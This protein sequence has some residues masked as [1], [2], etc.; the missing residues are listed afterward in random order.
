MSVWD[1]R[2]CTCKRVLYTITTG[3]NLMY[4]NRLIDNRYNVSHSIVNGSFY[5][6]PVFRLVLRKKS[7]NQEKN[8]HN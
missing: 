6:K 4:L 5:S 8:Y 1:A 7:K 2:V 3:C